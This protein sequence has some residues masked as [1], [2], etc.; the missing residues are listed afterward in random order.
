MDEKLNDK[1]ASLAGGTAVY[2]DAAA[3]APY[4]LHFFE[5]T[6]QG[7]NTKGYSLN[8]Y[9]EVVAVRQESAGAEVSGFSGKSA[10]FSVLP[11]DCLLNL[12]AAPGYETGSPLSF[13]A[14]Q[15]GPP[16]HPNPPGYRA[17]RASRAGNGFPQKH[18]PERAPPSSGPAL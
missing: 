2:V 11:A 4:C 17:A 6:V 16:P 1:L 13:G 18:L 12:L 9:G 5:I 14:S 8:L 10:I 3:P 15:A 7:Q